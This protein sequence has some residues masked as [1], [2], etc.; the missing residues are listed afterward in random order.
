MC[1]GRDHGR[2]AMHRGS[3][4][5][6]YVQ[7]IN[8]SRP[9]AGKGHVYGGKALRRVFLAPDD[10]DVVPSADVTSG[11]RTDWRHQSKR[12]PL[13]WKNDVHGDLRSPDDV[14][15]EKSS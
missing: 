15:H 12:R 3:S 2:E 14:R 13:N 6:A 1:V 9:L 8:G 11:A 5:V 7:S 10:A 4:I